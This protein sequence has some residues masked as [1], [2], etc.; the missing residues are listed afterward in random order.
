MGFRGLLT[1]GWRTAQGLDGLP[2][3]RHVTAHVGQVAEGS[4]F[5]R[6][7]Y[8]EGCDPEAQNFLINMHA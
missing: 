1:P 6:F 5:I 4:R 3:P 2:D 8:V 7:M